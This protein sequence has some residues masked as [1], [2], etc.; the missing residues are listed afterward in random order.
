MLF[1]ADYVRTIQRLS[2]FHIFPAL[3]YY[4]QADIEVNPF[5]IITKMLNS[6]E[7]S[8]EAVKKT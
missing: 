3:E 2:I 4:L 1:I 8:N 7:V 6:S 5:F